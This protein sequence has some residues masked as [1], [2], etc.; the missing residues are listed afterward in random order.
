MGQGPCRAG[1][2]GELVLGKTDGVLM[3]S[4]HRISEYT[5]SMSDWRLL[6]GVTGGVV[7]DSNHACAGAKA[8]GEIGPLS[9]YGTGCFGFSKNPLYYGILSLALG[10]PLL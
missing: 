7:T 6:L 5:Y 4:G 3:R 1:A 8:G 9:V 10:L 2:R